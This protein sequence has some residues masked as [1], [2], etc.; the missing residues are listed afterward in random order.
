[1]FCLLRCRGSNVQPTWRPR[2]LCSAYCA[3]EA[4]RFCLLGD[5]V[6]YA[7]LLRYRDCFVVPTYCA[8]EA[9]MLCLLG[10]RGFYDLPTEL[11][12]L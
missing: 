9:Q 5:R 6:C 8:A 12:R 1:M 7:L 4:V 10:D 3:T 2:L 11:P